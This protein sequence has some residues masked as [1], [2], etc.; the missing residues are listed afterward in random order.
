M[1]SD[2]GREVVVITYSEGSSDEAI[3]VPSSLSS[4]LSLITMTSSSSLPAMLLLHVLLET[5]E[6]LSRVLLPPLSATWHA[7]SKH[8]L[9]SDTL[10]FA[11]R[12]PPFFFP[13]S[14]LREKHPAKKSSFSI[15]AFGCGS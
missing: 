6:T 14:P 5:E 13:G 11:P 2:N 4:S 8:R 10:R 3:L 9:M 15:R 1:L 12:E 7:S